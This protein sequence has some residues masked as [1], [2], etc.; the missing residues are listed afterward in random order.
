MERNDVH[1]PSQIVPADYTYVLWYATATTVD[2]WPQPSIN[3]NC[4]QVRSVWS[5]EDNKIITIAGSH[6]PDGKC[7]VVELQRNFPFQT[8]GP[9]KCSVC[10]SWFVYG[11]VWRH[12]P[13]G[14]HVHIGHI[15]AEKY[16]LLRDRSDLEAWR[17]QQ[18]RER[19]TE[20]IK[21]ERK[22]KLDRF[23][24]AN[25]GLD[26]ALD[27]DHPISQDLKSKLK[28]YGDLSEKQV[29]LAFKLFDEV[30]NPKPEEKHVAA[31]LGRV[32]VRGLIVGTKVQDSP[33][34]SVRK[35]LVKVETP[36]GVWLCWSTMPDSVTAYKGDGIQFTATLEKS[37]DAHF[38]YA[39]RPTKATVFCYGCSATDGECTCKKEGKE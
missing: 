3:I 37:Q 15:C 8:F 19:A 12:D 9:G 27:I 33:W 30:R 24:A 20:I 35:M 7:C 4:Q 31:P 5:E 10:G 26:E 39:K 6:N 18:K 28:T 25:P 17:E 2:G 22:E 29:K 23:M 1:R 16:G 14:V 32:T 34:G 36:E 21:R 11:E 13:T 38:A